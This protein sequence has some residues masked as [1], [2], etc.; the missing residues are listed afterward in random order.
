MED[1]LE[2]LQIV[3]GNFDYQVGEHVCYIKS[4]R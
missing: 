3:I 2:V 1:I 4:R